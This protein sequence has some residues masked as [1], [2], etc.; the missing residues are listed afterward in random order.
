MVFLIIT[1]M[2]LLKYVVSLE[3]GIKE[4]LSEVYMENL[5]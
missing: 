4:C 3:F 2:L 1:N 5:S